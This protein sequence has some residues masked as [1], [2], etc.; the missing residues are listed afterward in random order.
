M[1]IGVASRACLVLLLIAGGV[2]AQQPPPPTL[3]EV[4]PQ[5]P[6][7]K[8]EGINEVPPGRFSVVP[9]L[10]GHL[11]EELPRILR[12]ARLRPGKVD[13]TFS[14]QPE[15]RVFDQ[16]P[17]AGA[18]VNPGT[19]VDVV[20]SRGEDK[21]IVPGVG[22]RPLETARQMLARVGLVV[23]EVLETPSEN[24][25][26]TVVD[27]KPGPKSV[28]PR[29]SPVS[30]MIAVAPIARIPVP[31]LIGRREDESRQALREKGLRT[32]VREERH[33]ERAAGTIVEQKPGAAT[34]VPP[35]TPVDFVVSA[36]PI[37]QTVP[38]PVS[39]F[40]P[41]PEPTPE[42]APTPAPR[43][44]PTFAPTP[45][46]P[47]TPLWPIGVLVAAVVAGA[48][49]LLRPRPTN[50]NG[51]RKNLLERIEIRP[52]RDEGRQ[53]LSREPEP[54]SRITLVVHRD[55]GTQRVRNV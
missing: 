40:T 41:P 1:K 13:F 28:V 32:G 26:R 3:H 5:K 9:S 38:S 12:L 47:P 30:L 31:D 10:I 4:V 37:V 51:N 29:G 42:P 2:A 23:G 52:Q 18:R 46:P 35:G 36:G 11:P 19:P 21:V 14:D 20:V 33:D 22:G 34:L 39:T 24:P 45:P 25:P 17:K 49:W 8:I 53:S 15:G 50:G 6:P 55:D 43:S 7:L 48:Y 54:Q 44:R 16:A 27:Q